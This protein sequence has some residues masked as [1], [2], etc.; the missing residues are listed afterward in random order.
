MNNKYFV[1]AMGSTCAMMWSI[2]KMQQANVA[3]VVILLGFA[4][5]YWTLA[6]LGLLIL[7]WTEK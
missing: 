3:W 7:S 4:A 1:G 2:E 5:A 6:A